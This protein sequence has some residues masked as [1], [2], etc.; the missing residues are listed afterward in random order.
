[1][2]PSCSTPGVTQ[3]K[4]PI[5][6]SPTYFETQSLNSYAEMLRNIYGPSQNYSKTKYEVLAHLSEVCGII[7]KHLFKKQDYLAAGNFIPKIFGWAC[8]LVEIMQPSSADIERII[9]QKFPTLCPYCQSQPCSC[10]SGEKPTLDSDALLRAYSNKANRAGRTLDD[11]DVMF[12]RIYGESRHDD[13][14]NP[15]FEAVYMRMIEELAEVAEAVRFHHLYPVNFENEIADFFGWWF[16]LSRLIRSYQTED[17]PTLSSVIWRAYPGNCRDCQS[18]PC[19]CLQG[20]VREL[21]S[22]PSPGHLHEIDTL[23][24]L[25]NQGAYL[26]DI[27]KITAGSETL[28][29][30]VGCVRV[31][32]DLF[33]TIN[34]SYGHIAGDE[35]LRHIANTLRKKAGPRTRIYRISGDEF[36]VL[37]PDSTEEEV[38]GLMKRVLAALAESPVR[39]VSAQ[40]KAVEFHVGLS[41]GV[42]ECAEPKMMGT[43]FERADKAAYVS[44]ETGRGRVTRYSDTPQEH[45]DDG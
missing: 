6:A 43:V 36:G 4:D 16:A 5:V 12:E 44:K 9:L 37:A 28:A 11:F 22:K 19:F 27:Q 25:R 41:V 40:G 7:G 33:K 8:A 34:D 35:A 10:W 45:P 13:S 39:W 1:M 17:P 29:F 38:T 23:T 42:A 14:G 21:I 20:P 32:V 3:L 24:S 18:T 2:L 26:A 31:D 15:R 30:P